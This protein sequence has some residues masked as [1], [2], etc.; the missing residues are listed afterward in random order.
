M[1]AS[2]LPPHHPLDG[3]LNRTRLESLGSVKKQGA[4][5]S[6]SP[7][8]LERELCR[9]REHPEMERVVVGHPQEAQGWTQRRAQEQTVVLDAQ[10]CQGGP[11]RVPPRPMNSCP[12]SRRTQLSEPTDMA[13][14]T[15]QER[16][17]W[18]WGGV[19]VRPILYTRFS[20]GK[21][22]D[23]SEV[24]FSFHGARRHLN[25]ASLRKRG[26][27]HKPWPLCSDPRTWVTPSIQTS[28]LKRRTQLQGVPPPT[29]H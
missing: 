4:H 28:S 7:V 24:F 21:L 27:F 12:E 11:K 16:E 19:H 17:R 2:H 26:D 22:S 13:W 14:N 5:W 29:G 3:V 8:C 6:S 10:E 25:Y 1:S 15:Q 9:G 18:G 20:H 23:L